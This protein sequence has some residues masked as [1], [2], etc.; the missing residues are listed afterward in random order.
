M[1]KR[2]KKGQGTLRCPWP[3][4]ASMILGRSWD[5]GYC[6][7]F[8]MD[9]LIAGV[10]G[11]LCLYGLGCGQEQKAAPF[12][13]KQPLP[14]GLT[15]DERKAV[16][17]L[18]SKGAHFQ[19]FDNPRVLGPAGIPFSSVSLGNDSRTSDADLDLLKQI[20]T[21]KHLGITSPQV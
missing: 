17:F 16:E 21:L 10:I 2:S 9:R 15:A 14:S 5:T 4:I 8:P 11:L 3:A 18:K 1:S 20:K 19:F 13:P 7:G 6:G 12:P